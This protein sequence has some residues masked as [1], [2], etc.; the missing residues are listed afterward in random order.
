MAST[1]ARWIFGAALSFGLAFAAD[2]FL[3]TW[4]L[5]MEKSKFAPSP[6]AKSLT[7]TREMVDGAMK[8]HTTGER[9]DG[10]AFNSD[11]TTKFDGKAVAWTGGGPADSIAPKRV[12]DHTLTSVSTKKGTKYKATGRTVVSADGKTMTTTSHG[13]L[14]DGR[15]FHYTM[16]S[17]KQ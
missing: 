1:A 14:A 17:D 5:N 7:T 6:I 11:F 3:G 10:T 4:K 12:N 16:V 13:T 9:N 2:S 8:V 15:P